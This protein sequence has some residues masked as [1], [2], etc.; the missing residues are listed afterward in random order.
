MKTIIFLL[1]SAGILFLTS[2][3]SD[4]QIGE[5]TFVH[6]DKIYRVI[7]N[8]VREIGDL[9]AKEIKRFEVSKP[10]QKDLGMSSMSFVKPGAYAT[11]KALY[12]GNFLYYTLTVNGLNDLRDSYN[13]GS[14]TIEFIDE[15]GFIMHSTEIRTNEL[16]GEL[17]D[18]GKYFDFIYHGKTE[19]STEINA[20]IKRYDV[21]ASIKRRSYYGY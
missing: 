15:F 20:A 11:L 7:D 12:R 9:S 4:T 5:N 18:N 13:A 17:G 10:K 19:M 14:L 2:C 21:T 8:E 6:K 3:G 1:L 16:I